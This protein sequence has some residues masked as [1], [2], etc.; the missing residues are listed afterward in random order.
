MT[1][2]APSQSGSCAG[3]KATTI[4]TE[5]LG[6]RTPAFALCALLVWASALL[7]SGCKRADT[8]AAQGAFVSESAFQRAHPPVAC[9]D[10]LSKLAQERGV[11]GTKGDTVQTFPWKDV[12][13]EARVSL[14]RGA[15]STAPVDC[16]LG[17]YGSLVTLKERS[18]KSGDAPLVAG[19]GARLGSADLVTYAARVCSGAGAPPSGPTAGA[20]LTGRLESG[21]DLRAAALACRKT[22]PARSEP[23][24]ACLRK[25]AAGTPEAQELERKGIVVSASEAR[26]VCAGAAFPSRPAGCLAAFAGSLG[27]SAPGAQNFAQAPGQREAAFAL[28][29]GNDVPDVVSCFREAQ[30]ARVYV[31]EAAPSATLTSLLSARLCGRAD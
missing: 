29:R 16:V 7:A 1:D 8:A 10:R 17:A 24:D 2:H 31:S 15:T 11:R 26:S 5:G 12:T 27:G 22:P 20:C 23:T 3:T 9:L 21:S 4:A 28:C 25:F 19:L 6:E 30:S 13:P 14:C 18:A